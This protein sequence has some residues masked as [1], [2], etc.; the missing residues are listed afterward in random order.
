MVFYLSKFLVA[1]FPVFQRMFVWMQT[2][3]FWF[4]LQKSFLFIEIDC[5]M[6]HDDWCKSWR[7]SWQPMS[8][9]YDVVWSLFWNVSEME[10]RT[11]MNSAL[12]PRENMRFSGICL[13]RKTLWPIGK[14]AIRC[15][16]EWKLRAKFCLHTYIS[17]YIH[18]LL[19]EID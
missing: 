5:C 1:D 12:F 6:L 2:F 13:T 7:L 11:A 9:F 16:N 15:A 3:S 17:T 10:L 8:T 4:I 18:L 14:N 19:I